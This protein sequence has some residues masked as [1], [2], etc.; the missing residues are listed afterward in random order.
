LSGQLPEYDERAIRAFLATVQFA[1]SAQ[2]FDAAFPEILEQA[3]TVTSLRD[4]PLVVLT[5]GNQEA[6]SAEE[7]RILQEMQR[8]LQALSTDSMYIAVEGATHVSLV[9]NRDHAQGTI[10]RLKQVVEA[11]RLGEPLIQ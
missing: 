9:H 4:V 10:D 7:N 5:T 3:R 8:E 11:V 2:Q 6:L 1:E